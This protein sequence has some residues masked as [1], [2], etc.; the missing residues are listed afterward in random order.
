MV[1]DFQNDT[2][3]LDEVSPPAP[4]KAQTLLK[5]VKTFLEKA[6]HADLE[7]PPNAPPPPP[8]EEVRTN[9]GNTDTQANGTENVENVE[10]SHPQPTPPTQTT[11]QNA[12]ESSDSSETTNVTDLL[13]KLTL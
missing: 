12:A 4:E 7:L 2:E 3:K 5:V 6:W 13:K 8:Y 1:D 9:E 10:N 11:T